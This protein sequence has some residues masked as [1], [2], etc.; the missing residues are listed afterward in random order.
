MAQVCFDTVGQFNNTCQFALRS[1]AGGQPGQIDLP[2][3]HEASSQIGEIFH[4]VQQ[5]V[6]RLLAY[7]VSWTESVLLQTLPIN[8]NKIIRGQ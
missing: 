3:L 7:K 8:G 2:M 6:E 5:L 4:A 1:F